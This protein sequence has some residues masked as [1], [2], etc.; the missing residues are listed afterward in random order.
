MLNCP[1]DINLPLEGCTTT[2]S[3]FHVSARAHCK[4]VK[5]DI[6]QKG[7]YSLAI[8][9]LMVRALLVL[10]SPGLR[11]SNLVS[12][13][14]ALGIFATAA[15]SIIVNAAIHLALVLA[16]PLLFSLLGLLLL[17]LFQRMVFKYSKHLIPC[18]KLFFLSPNLFNANRDG[19]L[20]VS[21]F[22][23]H[24]IGVYENY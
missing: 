15:N 18:F 16:L 10:F 9:C 11:M 20:T 23:I 13:L 5:R 3:T 1:T 22:R 24:W 12:S 14:V 21:L 8:G 2:W 17:A 6:N 7:K 4:P 19:H